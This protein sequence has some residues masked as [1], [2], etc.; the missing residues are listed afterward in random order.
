VRSARAPSRSGALG[1]RSVPDTSRPAT[2]PSRSAV[3]A[4]LAAVDWPKVY[5]QALGYAFSR[6]RSKADAQGQ[7]NESI[8]RVFDPEHNPWN[9][10]THPDVTIFLIGIVSRNVSTDRA[11]ARCHHEIT[12][13]S[14]AHD[15]RVN[16][17]AERVPSRKPTP[18]GALATHDFFARRLAALR[19]RAAADPLVHSLIDAMDEWTVGR[20][21][22][23][24]P[25]VRSFDAAMVGE[26]AWSPR[27]NEGAVQDFDNA[28]PPTAHATIGRGR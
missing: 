17:V 3:D 23:G 6:T 7:A 14:G 24:G 26:S 15:I 2:P 19:A 21:V 28:S 27:R 12:V 4:A 16:R 22:R 8:R 20:S 9:P 1:L 5:R 13:Q 10:A 11:S 25:R 18:E